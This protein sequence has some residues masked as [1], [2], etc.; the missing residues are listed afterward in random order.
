[1]MKTKISFI[2]V[3]ESITLMCVMYLIVSFKR[4]LVQLFTYHILI[5]ASQV[6][7]D[8]A[9]DPTTYLLVFGDS[10]AKYLVS[11]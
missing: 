4:L 3:S 11:F 2:H 10:E 1:M 5:I 7:G 9:D 6:R 8:D